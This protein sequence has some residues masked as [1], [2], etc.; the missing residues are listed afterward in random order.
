MSIF[1]LNQS[2]DGHGPYVKTVHQALAI[3][4]EREKRGE[5]RWPIVVPLTHPRQGHIIQE[6]IESDCSDASKRLYRQEIYFDETLGDL[7]KEVRFDGKDYSAHLENLAR[8]YFDVE[9]K[10]HDYLS[11]DRVVRRFDGETGKLD[12][13]SATGLNM[14]H[15]VQ[16]GLGEQYYFSGGSGPFDLLL[17]WG[18]SDYRILTSRSA[19]KGVQAIAKRLMEGQRAILIPEP[20]CFSWNPGREFGAGLNEIPSPPYTHFPKK[21]PIEETEHLPK[22]GLYVSMSGIKGIR[23]NGF[24]SI[25]VERG[26]PIYTPGSNLEELAKGLPEGTRV[27]PL[28]PDKFNSDVIDAMYARS[29]WSSVW[30]AFLAGKGFI[31][32]DYERADDIEMRYNL[33]T[34]RALGLGVVLNGEDWRNVIQSIEMADGE[35]ESSAKRL[36]ETLEREYKTLDGIRYGAG[37]VVKH[38][39]GEDV[40]EYEKDTVITDIDES[41]IDLDLP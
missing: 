24:Y 37:F 4:D 30:A 1:L 5:E 27:L 34:I 9:K 6:T 39:A 7:L 11:R 18:L 29:G 38:M 41:R 8:V 19:M 17:M 16:T 32:R 2:P 10:V 33:M 14:N 21:V 31:T 23:D 15:K 36:R 35:F 3:N 25:V 20:D 40:S 28:E 13:S 26:M 12:L 22:G